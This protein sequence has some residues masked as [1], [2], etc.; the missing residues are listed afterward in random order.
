[1]KYRTTQREV[2]ANYPIVIDILRGHAQNLLRFETPV[3]YIEKRDGWA[4][5][6]YDIGRGVAIVTGRQ[7]CYNCVDRAKCNADLFEQL[8]QYEDTD[9]TPEEVQTM[10]RLVGDIVA[11]GITPEELGIFIR[12]H[13]DRV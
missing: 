3:A 4:A 7:P 10:K 5:D 1:M 13:K 9:M 8:A 6:V 11:T 2:R 12:A